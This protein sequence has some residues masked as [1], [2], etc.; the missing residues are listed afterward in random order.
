[1][2]TRMFIFRNRGSGSLASTIDLLGQDRPKM[3]LILGVYGVQD[4]GRQHVGSCMVIRP[5][6]LLCISR[7][8]SAACNQLWMNWQFVIRRSC[9]HPFRLAHLPNFHL[10]GTD[11]VLTARSLG[12]TAYAAHMPV[13]HNSRPKF[14]GRGYMCILSLYA[15]EVVERGYLFRPPSFR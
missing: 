7:R 3:G 5:G 14:L 12:R 4:S 11:I 10:Y 13:I 9:A 1:M 8:A 15:T 2:R 6:S